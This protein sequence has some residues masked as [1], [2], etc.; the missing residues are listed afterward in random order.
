VRAPVGEDVTHETDYHV[1]AGDP[2]V[3]QMTADEG[4]RVGSGRGRN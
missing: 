4:E 1:E 3:E 2:G